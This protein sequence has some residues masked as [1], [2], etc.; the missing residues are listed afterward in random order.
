MII[1][2]EYSGSDSKPETRKMT[3]SE[4]QRFDQSGV[5]IGIHNPETAKL[6]NTKNSSRD[7]LQHNGS[8]DTINQSN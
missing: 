8:K 7:E 2:E 3:G 4:L 5:N 6:D 1:K